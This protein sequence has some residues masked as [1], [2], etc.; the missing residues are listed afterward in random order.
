MIQTSV[1]SKTAR[2]E[3]IIFDLVVPHLSDPS[4]VVISQGTGA[5]LAVAVSMTIAMRQTPS[6]EATRISISQSLRPVLRIFANLLTFF[7]RDFRDKIKTKT[8]KIVA[9]LYDS[10]RVAQLHA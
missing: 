10:K 5:I 7:N 8:I 9:V 6:A 1:H 3:S 2:S 4:T